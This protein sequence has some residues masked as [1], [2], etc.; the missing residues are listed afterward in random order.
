M[1]HSPAAPDGALPLLATK[2]FVPRPRPDLVARPRLLGRL[3]EGLATGVCTVLSAPAGAGKTSLLAA[4]AAELDRSVAWLTLDERDQ[5]VPQVLRYLS[6]AAQAIV[7]G[8]RSSWRDGT[9]PPA[10]TVLT[11]LVNEIACANASGLLVLDDYHVVHSP[12]VHA[13]VTFLLDHLPPGLHLVVAS[14]E[15]PPLPLPRLRA[16]GQLVE[17]RGT[18]LGFTVEEADALLA[19][20]TRLTPS[21]VVT[22]VERT[23]GWA[24]GLQLAALALRGRPD[25]AEFVAA[26]AGGHRLVADYL[27]AEVLAQLPERTRS[28][29]TATAV[30]DRLSASLCDAVTER[31][32][33]QQILEELERANLFVVPLDD[34]R[35]WYRYH[36]LFADMLRAT[37]GRLGGQEQAAVV[38]RRAGA[39]FARRRLLPEAIQHA[40]AAGAHEDA[41]RWLESLTPVMFGSIDVHQAMEGWLAALPDALVRSR[42]TLCLARAWLLIHHLQIPA[43]AGWA[44][45]AQRALPPDAEPRARGAVAALLALLATLGPGADPED[46][47]ALARRALADLPDADVPF[48]GVAAVAHGQ[49]AMALGRADEAEGA[50]TRAA[51]EGR[52]AGLVL[53]ALVVAG[54]QV[55]VQRLRG[56]RLRALATGRAALAWGA[57]RSSAATRGSGCCRYW[58]PTCWPTATTRPMPWR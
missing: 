8:N 34:E 48:R 46:A 57:G 36:H 31:D 37:G 12:P 18:D 2:L 54:H 3:H 13:A 6:A 25:P 24:A 38:H 56:A 21:Q 11:E 1:P 43:A 5:D 4:W 35:T 9:M 30:L 29:L 50:L 45:E 10:E 47:C 15:D 17:L 42:P 53:G 26:F 27:S 44:Q 16:G 58:W 32:D 28:F 51:E 20:R 52:A 41:A 40:L 23:E 39:W 14:R 19:P 33:G 55:G 7:P 22:L 49:A